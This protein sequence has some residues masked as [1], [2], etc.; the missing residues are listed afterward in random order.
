ML[1]L[2]KYDRPYVLP[3]IIIVAFVLWGGKLFNPQDIVQYYDSNSMPLFSL[4]ESVFPSGTILSVIISITMMLLNFYLLIRINAKY[5]LIRE[6]TFLPGFIYMIMV[7]SYHGV[8]EL[9]PLLF[10]STFL[11]IGILIIFSTYRSGKKLSPFFN[12]SF[13][14][15]VGS[16]FYFNLIYFEVFL[17]LCLVS[18]RTFNWREWFSVIIGSITPW[19][20][21]FGYFF[22]NQNLEFL[23]QNIV[24]NFTFFEGYSFMTLFYILFYSFS[25][26]LFL[27]SFLVTFSGSIKKV[28]TLKQYL[29]L[30]VLFVLSIILFFAVPA[31]SGELMVIIAIP[32][33]YF[34]ANYLININSVALGEVVFTSYIGLFVAQMIIN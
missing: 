9:N 29:L 7:S 27:I 26:F 22:Y 20:F 11:L 3:L 16:L 25:L 23:I 18:L 28:E 8:R 33:S 21:V 2:L 14:V 5:K 19:L 32:F 10:A 1:T 6:G 30:F 34:L 12:A 13:F 31:T 24:V 15:A 17:L 4:V